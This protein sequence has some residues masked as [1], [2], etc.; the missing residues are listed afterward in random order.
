MQTAPGSITE[1]LRSA[2]MRLMTARD[3]D[4]AP[5]LGLSGAQGSGKS[6]AVET[7]KSEM[8]DRLA[9]LSLDDFYLTKAERQRLA[10]KVSPLLATRGAPGTHDV[11]W[12]A[13]AVARL[14]TARPDDATHLPRFEKADDDRAP[15]ERWVAVRGRPDLIVVE[16]WCVGALAPP[17]YLT[18]PPLN[19]AERQDADLACRRLQHAQLTGPYLDLWRGFDAFVHLVPPSWETVSVWRKQQEIGN[20][21]LGDGLLPPDRAAWVD[22]FVQHYERIT[23]AM[24][25]GYRMPGEIVRLDEQRRVV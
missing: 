1:S 6:T 3:P 15:P 19:D 11:L 7:L 25:A 2:A 14:K 21:A 17:D 20:L 8:G 9:V 16:G 13:E 10:T 22:G 18:A 4:A 12:L 24:A 23:R 5:V